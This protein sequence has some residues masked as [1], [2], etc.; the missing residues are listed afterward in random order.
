MSEVAGKMATQIGAQF[1]ERNHAGKG[2]LLGVYQV[3][4]VG[5]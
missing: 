4:N 2:I 3:Y 1:L 5:K